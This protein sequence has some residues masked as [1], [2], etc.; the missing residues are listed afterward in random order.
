MHVCNARVRTYVVV[1]VGR[2]V[3]DG[4]EMGWGSRISLLPDQQVMLVVVAP[5]LQNDVCTA[6]P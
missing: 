6:T 2:R 5:H 4:Q 3:V 1:R